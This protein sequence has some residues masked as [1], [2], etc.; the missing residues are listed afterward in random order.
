M[1]G[2]HKIFIWGNQQTS[3]YL[4]K[5]TR[6]NHINKTAIDMSKIVEAQKTRKII[7][8]QAVN[9]KIANEQLK[10]GE[11]AT[12]KQLARLCKGRSRTNATFVIKKNWEEKTAFFCFFNLIKAFD[13]CQRCNSCI[14]DK[15]P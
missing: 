8:L 6:S 11:T 4:V 10:Y 12:I 3:K 2:I 1:D 14:I 15:Y 9:N 13:R 5:I 7:R